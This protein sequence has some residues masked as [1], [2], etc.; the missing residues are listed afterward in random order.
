MVEDLDLVFD[1]SRRRRAIDPETPLGPQ[2]RTTLWRL[3]KRVMARAG[4]GM[5]AGTQPLPLTILR[6]LLGH[7]K[8]CH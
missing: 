3:E 5:L 4:I 1:L 7:D 2:D 8:I 6:D